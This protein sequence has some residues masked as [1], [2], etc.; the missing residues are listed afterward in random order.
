MRKTSV[1]DTAATIAFVVAGLGCELYL[2]PAPSNDRCIFL[3]V[4]CVKQEQH[5]ALALAPPS[6]NE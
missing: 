3:G 1:E 6:T 4:I 2:E 5:P